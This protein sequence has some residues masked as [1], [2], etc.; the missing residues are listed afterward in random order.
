LSADERRCT[1]IF[2]T[3]FSV[4]LAIQKWNF[5]DGNEQEETE[6]A[7]KTGKL[8]W[9]ILLNSDKSHSSPSSAF[10]CGQIISEV[11]SARK[12]RGVQLRASR[13]I[14]N[15]QSKLAVIRPPQLEY[16]FYAEAQ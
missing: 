7:E 16:G 8:L 1:Q 12:D 3:K 2:K 10:I 6:D 11:Q 4:N 14:Q 15:S 5:L 9:F 13:L